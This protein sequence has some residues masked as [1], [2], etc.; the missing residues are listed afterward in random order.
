MHLSGFI[1]SDKV[2]LKNI[3]YFSGINTLTLINADLN[4]NK[5]VCQ[6]FNNAI[7]LNY[8]YTNSIKTKKIMKKYYSIIDYD[9][10]KE[11]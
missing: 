7:N 4:E 3:F 2:N 9:K 6:V 1:I 10:N 8:L 11:K 5:K